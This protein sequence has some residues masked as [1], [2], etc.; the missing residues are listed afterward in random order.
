MAVGSY[1]LSKHSD[2]YMLCKRQPGDRMNR[3]FYAPIG[4]VNVS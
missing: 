3:H 2:S 4:D 1:I